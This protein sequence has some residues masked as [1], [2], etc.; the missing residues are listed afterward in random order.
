MGMA[1]GTDEA[2]DAGEGT[3]RSAKLTY[4]G[5]EVDLCLCPTHAHFSQEGITRVLTLDPVTI[6]FTDLTIKLQT[7]IFFTEGSAGIRMERKILEMSRPEAEV[8]LNEYMVACYGTTEY[9]EDMSGITLSAEKGADALTLAYE[10]KCRE[11]YVEGADRVSAVIPP[12]QTKV[13][14]S[15]DRKD[16]TGYFKEG[17]AFSPMFTLGYQTKISDKEVFSTWLSLEKAN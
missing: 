10:Y 11:E 4:K 15:C 6:E 12:V 13:S 1:A 17:Y 9:T 5:E 8:E 2:H 3:V 7:R 16:A 14:M